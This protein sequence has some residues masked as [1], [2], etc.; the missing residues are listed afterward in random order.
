MRRHIYI[1]TVIALIVVAI[2]LLVAFAKPL[3]RIYGSVKI[4]EA[5]KKGDVAEIR[6]IL[7]KES[8]AVNS[9]ATYV[10]EGLYVLL[11]DH[12]VPYPLIEACYTDNIEIVKLL[13]EAGADVNCYNGTTPL[14]VV[15]Q[16]K[17]DNWYEISQYLIENG[18]SLDYKTANSGGVS[19]VFY[20]IV[21]T[22]SGK[23]PQTDEEEVTTAFN[24]ALENCDHS[25]VNWMRVLQH[26]VTNDRIEI[27][28]LLLDQ[29]YCDVNDTSVGMTA[30]MFAARDSTLEM[31]QLLLD[32]GADKSI[33]SYDGKTAYDYA[34]D[35][36][37]DEIISVL[38]D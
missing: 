7:Q 25:N 8:S 32:Y 2:V 22:S 34:V 29:K 3:G 21:Q 31:V 28:K 37:N 23:G 20:D 26:A 9:P 16:S 17:K 5:I 24:Y 27:V 12:H 6:K 30:L 18:A 13:V 19:A 36:K 33:L 15:Y 10:P 14:S 11:T 4:V 1:V 35:S 38:G